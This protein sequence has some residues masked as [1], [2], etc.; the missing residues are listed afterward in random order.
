MWPVQRARDR[1]LQQRTGLENTRQ[2][3][4]IQAGLG[5]EVQAPAIESICRRQ[6][7]GQRGGDPG[8][9]PRRQQ[10]VQIAGLDPQ[11][12][13]VGTQHL[14]AHVLVAR[15]AAPSGHPQ[16]RGQDEWTAFGVRQSGVNQHG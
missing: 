5:A 15:G 4:K 9:V 10:P 3:G 11:Q 14:A 12:A 6:C 8:N 16:L 13:V 7:M 1:G 2:D